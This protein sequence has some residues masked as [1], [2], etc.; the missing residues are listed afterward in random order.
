[1]DWASVLAPCALVSA[2]SLLVVQLT[3]IEFLAME[4]VW[5]VISPARMAL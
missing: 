5:V 3:Q 1:M 4:W 2:S